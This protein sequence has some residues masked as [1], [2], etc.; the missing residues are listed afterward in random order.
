M[1]PQPG[2]SSCS[3]QSVIQRTRISLQVL[4]RLT[5]QCSSV[6]PVRTSAEL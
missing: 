2:S 6:I 1:Y 5:P 3:D 4:Q